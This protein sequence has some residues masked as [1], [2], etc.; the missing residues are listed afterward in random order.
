[1]TDEIDTEAT[2]DPSPQPPE[3]LGVLSARAPAIVRKATETLLA[4]FEEHGYNPTP[5]IDLGVIIAAA[6]GEIAERELKALRSVVGTLLG[7]KLK[8]EVVAHLVQASYEVLKQAGT[9]PRVRLVAEIL[10]DVGAVEPGFVVAI[11]VGYADRG[12][13]AAERK[14]LATLASAAGL[15]DARVDEL[16]K[17]VGAA[18]NAK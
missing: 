12:V 17:Q 14:T 7:E 1:M 15:D 8:P 11:A 9:E 3:S 5:L 4:R 18:L 13:N 10:K 6:D 16:V 2:S